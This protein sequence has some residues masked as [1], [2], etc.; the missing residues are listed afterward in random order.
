MKVELAATL[1]MLM[2][3]LLHAALVVVGLVALRLPMHAP[4]P[5]NLAEGSAPAADPWVGETFDI[6]TASNPE[7][8]EDKPSNPAA[9]PTPE[10]PTPVDPAPAPMP[11]P[12]PSPSEPAVPATQDP[13][14]APETPQPAEP[15]APA[16]AS[17]IP[18]PP[19]ASPSSP[20]PP[21]PA[22]AASSSSP[23]AAPAVSAAPALASA[24]PATSGSP[25]S[26]TGRFGAAGTRRGVRNLA[27]AFARAMPI[28]NSADPVWTTLPVGSAGSLDV[29]LEVGDDGKITGA[30][31]V[32]AARAPQHLV[33]LVQRTLTLLR[34]GR[35]AL[36]N[37]DASA[38]SET[39]RLEARIEQVE[40][41]ADDTSAGPYALGF[42]APTRD[43]K[44]HATFTL[45]TG[46]RITVELSLVQR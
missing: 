27:T 28:A 39:Y 16:I 38:G 12:T 31:P 30:K 2:S 23:A 20:K 3:V 18:S 41:A 24:V 43:T 11:A 46:R 14:V 29:T 25:G 42:K 32:D 21:V 8:A 35:F 7:E 34:A 15:A 40:A 44:G 37:P 5:Q 22:S 19:A 4:A 33:R 10:P 6:D 45:R 9:A 13:P 17:A 26:G 36:T 1:S